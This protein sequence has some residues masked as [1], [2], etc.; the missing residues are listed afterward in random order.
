[1]ANWIYGDVST[2][3]IGA[4]HLV[5][6]ILLSVT[7]M[8]MIGIQVSLGLDGVLRNSITS[9]VLF[10]LGGMHVRLVAFLDQ[11]EREKDTSP[12]SYV[13]SVI[14]ERSGGERRRSE[15][16]A[17]EWAVGG[18]SE[19][20]KI[21]VVKSQSGHHF[22]INESPSVQELIVHLSSSGDNQSSEGKERGER[23]KASSEKTDAFDG[24]GPIIH[25]N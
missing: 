18:R 17:D 2:S 23:Q 19:C 13:I 7:G 5:T 3:S 11:V 4:G 25:A 21:V 15:I 1:M 24:I 12:F 8:S 14:W 20:R 6:S 10:F 9:A 22:V 16:N